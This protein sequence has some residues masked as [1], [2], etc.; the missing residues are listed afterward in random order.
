M[1]YLLSK[2]VKTQI[3]LCLLQPVN[4]W[5]RHMHDR[6]AQWWLGMD[7]C[8]HVTIGFNWFHCLYRIY[9]QPPWLV[10]MVN[11]VLR[12]LDTHNDWLS[13]T[14]M[15]QNIFTHRHTSVHTHTHTYCHIHVPRNP[16][17]LSNRLLPSIFM[18]CRIR[19]KVYL[20]TDISN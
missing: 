12:V 18:A 15:Q 20:A 7:M 19:Y 4:D 8:T 3:R 10:N 5:P 17:F 2:E 14:Q 13:I 6:W 11:F 1:L 9:G 16:F